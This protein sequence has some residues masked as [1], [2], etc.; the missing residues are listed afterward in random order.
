MAPSLMLPTMYRS[1]VVADHAR[2]GISTRWD[3][4]DCRALVPVWP[5]RMIKT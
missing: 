4:T 1:L 3:T 2:H 5:V